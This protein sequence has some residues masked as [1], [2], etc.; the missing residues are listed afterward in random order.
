MNIIPVT[1]SGWAKISGRS[2]TTIYRLIK[3]GELMVERDGRSTMICGDQ[4]IRYERLHTDSRLP[5]LPDDALAS[6][7]LYPADKIEAAARCYLN[8]KHRRRSPSGSYDKASRWFPE[9]VERQDCC[10]QIA[11]PSRAHPFGLVKHCCTVTHVAQLF[12]VDEAEL[13]RRANGIEAVEDIE[14][15]KAARDKLAEVLGDE[16]LAHAVFEEGLRGRQHKM[17]MGNLDH[18][19][20]LVRRALRLATGP[21]AV[22]LHVYCRLKFR[23]H[24]YEGLKLA[25]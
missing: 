7:I 14:G 11:A 15:I 9:A 8:R 24:V 12:R 4:A 19:K 18:T 10:A 13:R 5:M 23:Q 1:V 17:R 25:G 20:T 22:R 16:G 2:T 21:V 6:L 3:S